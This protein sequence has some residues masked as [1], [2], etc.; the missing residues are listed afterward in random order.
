MISYT[1]NQI[2]NPANANEIYINQL[3]L[4]NVEIK[5]YKYRITEYLQ[6]S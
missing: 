4:A 3:K 2:I 1:I 5:L 6:R